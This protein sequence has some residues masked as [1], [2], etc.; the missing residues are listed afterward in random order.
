MLLLVLFTSLGSCRP[1]SRCE[2]DWWLR[3]VKASLTNTAIPPIR[4][5]LTIYE[6]TIFA[7]TPCAT[8]EKLPTWKLSHINDFSN[9]FNGFADVTDFD[10][11]LT[12]WGLTELTGGQDFSYMFWS[13]PSFTNLGEP[14][15]LNVPS[16]EL[17]TRMFAQTTSLNATVQNYRHDTTVPFTGGTQLRMFAHHANKPMDSE[18]E[19][20]VKTCPPEKDCVVRNQG[21][22]EMLMSEYRRYDNL[23]PIKDINTWDVSNV[24]TLCYFNAALFASLGNVNI[25]APDRPVL[26]LRNWNLASVTDTS[27]MTVA[28]LAYP[29]TTFQLNPQTNALWNTPTG[30][31]HSFGSNQPSVTLSLP[32]LQRADGM[33]LYNFEM[34]KMALRLVDLPPGVSARYFLAGAVEFTGPLQFKPPNALRDIDYLISS[35]EFNYELDIDFTAVESARNLFS[36]VFMFAKTWNNSE[37]PLM[38]NLSVQLS[39]CKSCNVCEPIENM[40][41]HTN[42]SKAQMSRFLCFNGATTAEEYD[43]MYQKFG[44]AP[45]T[46]VF[47]GC[48]ETF[49]PTEQP[50]LPPTMTPSFVPSTAPSQSPQVAPTPSPTLQYTT[51]YLKVTPVSPTSFGLLEDNLYTF[52]GSFTETQLISVDQPTNEKFTDVTIQVKTTLSVDDMMERLASSDKFTFGFATDDDSNTLQLVTGAIFAVGGFITLVLYVMV[53]RLDSLAIDAAWGYLKP[54]K[55]PWFG[56]TTITAASVVYFV[57]YVTFESNDTDLVALISVSVFIAGAILWPI[58]ILR[59]TY[60]VARVGVGLTAV[61][62]IGF[63]VYVFMIEPSPSGLL[64]ASSIQAAVHHCIVDGAWAITTKSPS[65]SLSEPLL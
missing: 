64:I 14:L 8:I 54:Y 24:Q 21:H 17:F 62:S 61:G 42:L 60:A 18:H 33:F 22:A 58:G 29:A 10:V 40:L 31:A 38:W 65:Y 15:V 1:V 25:D 34:D 49:E 41:K 44:D 59:N 35:P 9:L 7:E 48:Q 3:Q 30:R 45:A 11:N 23:E 50:S 55:W 52:F 20:K 63:V 47:D 46:S 56:F 12:Q 32:S 36:P 39:S 13:V 53:S 57:Y 4:T 2:L 5:D 27:F 19:W 37:M 26:K 51:I 28:D 6:K 16:A 43:C